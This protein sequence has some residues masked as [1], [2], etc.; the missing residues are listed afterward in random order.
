MGSSRAQGAGSSTMFGLKK[1]LE[2]WVAV[3]SC[4]NRE[5]ILRSCSGKL[6]GV[7]INRL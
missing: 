2:K 6:I 3:Q 1:C 4:K 7:E 5:K